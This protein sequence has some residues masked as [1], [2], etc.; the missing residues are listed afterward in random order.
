MTIAS[1]EK[2]TNHLKSEKS[3]VGRE[4]SNYLT[5]Y[6]DLALQGTDLQSRF[7]Q[8]Q[9]HEDAAML[10]LL[11]VQLV[12]VDAKRISALHTFDKAGVDA[13]NN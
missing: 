12:V 10:A 6:P 2:Q 4:H 8:I 1:H 9:F 13:N 5:Q 3:S 11:L 7:Q